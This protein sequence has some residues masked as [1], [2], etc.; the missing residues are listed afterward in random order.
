METHV[1]PSEIHRYPQKWFQDPC[2]GLLCVSVS[3]CGDGRPML[4]AQQ[5]LALAY[6]F[7]GM[8]S[9]IQ[10]RHLAGSLQGG[11]NTALPEIKAPQA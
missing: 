6:G 3:A 7:D 10:P 1:P 2:W 5:K 4:V 11:G 9:L 8:A